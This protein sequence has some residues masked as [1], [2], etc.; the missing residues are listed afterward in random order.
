MALSEE[1]RDHRRRYDRYRSRELYWSVFKG[2]DRHAWSAAD[3]ARLIA[4]LAINA[5]VNLQAAIVGRSESAVIERRQDLRRRYG[6]AH[7][8]E[9]A[10]PDQ[11]RA[12]ITAVL[13][14]GMTYTAAAARFRVTRSAIA[15]MIR[16]HK[17]RQPHAH[18][19]DR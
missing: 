14:E 7:R 12:A 4:L 1:A 2:P 8:R 3:D 19:L 13:S 5:P 10:T 17:L 18:Q 15:G 16:R 11:R 9:Q 6:V